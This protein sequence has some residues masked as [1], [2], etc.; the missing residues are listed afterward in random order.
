[1]RQIMKKVHLRSIIEKEE[2][3]ADKKIIKLIDKSD[4]L[5]K[6]LKEFKRLDKEYRKVEF[7]VDP[8]AERRKHSVLKKGDNVMKNVEN[9][10]SEIHIQMKDVY[11]L[12][13][14]TRKKIGI[15]INTDDQ[16]K[17][18]SIQKIR[19]DE[20]NDEKIM[21]R[22]IDILVQRMSCFLSDF[23]KF[24]KLFKEYSKIEFRVDPSAEK[25]KEQILEKD[26]NLTKKLDIDKKKF[27]KNMEIMENLIGDVHEKI[28]VI[29]KNEM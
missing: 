7:R 11:D 24:K 20:E 1:M 29:L 13:G 16:I 28:K 9:L 12:L 27:N 5:T 3:I 14:K 22:K 10:S 6:N 21:D 26:L 17:S 8:T 19:Q 25:K 18:Q 4:N 15:L 23:K 2:R